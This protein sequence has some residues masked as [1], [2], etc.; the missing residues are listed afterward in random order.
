MEIA[1][2]NELLSREEER[3]QVKTIRVFHNNKRDDI[4]LFGT[5]R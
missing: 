5:F 4:P 2:Y 1:S 3:L